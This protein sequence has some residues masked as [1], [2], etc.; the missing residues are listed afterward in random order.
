MQEYADVVT[1]TEEIL[2]KLY[3]LWTEVHGISVKIKLKLEE[4]QLTLHPSKHFQLFHL[5]K[6]NNEQLIRKT[7]P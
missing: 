3:F 6:K 1:F 4:S 7:F 5:L 2:N